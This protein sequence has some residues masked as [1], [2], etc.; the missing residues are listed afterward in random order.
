MAGWE[1]FPPGARSAAGG[2]ALVHSDGAAGEAGCVEISHLAN[3]LAN[4]HGCK[5]GFAR[6][7]AFDPAF[8]RRA[9]AARQRFGEHTALQRTLERY[10][11]SQG[12]SNRLSNV[13]IARRG[14]IDKAGF[15]TWADGCHEIHG[16]RAAKA[17]MH[18]LALLQTGVGDIDGAHYRSSAVGRIGTEIDHDRRPRCARHALHV[19]CG[20]RQRAGE[21]S[22]I[23]VDKQSA[24]IVL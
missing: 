23:A 22:D 7:A 10:I 20:E 2:L 19:D 21:T 24:Y 16:V 1:S 12:V 6:R 14:F 4:Q 3:T 9:I 11:Q 17:A 13:G 15:E 8:Y 5:P 18:A